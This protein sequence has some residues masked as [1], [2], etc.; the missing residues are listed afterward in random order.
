[1]PQRG[2]PWLL[3]SWLAMCA[4]ATGAEQGQPVTSA[5]LQQ[6]VDLSLRDAARRTQLDTAQLR[7]SLA[8]AVTWPDASLGCPQPGREYA[9]VL[10]SGYRIRIV[11][12]D[13]TLEYHASVRGTPFLCPAERVRPPAASDPRT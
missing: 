4:Q 12:G 13:R 10:V 8:E 7:V 3:A 6:Q 5:T 1:V 2:G 11:A 9:Q